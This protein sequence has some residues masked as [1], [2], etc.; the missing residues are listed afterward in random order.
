MLTLAKDDPMAKKVSRPLRLRLV[1]PRLVSLRGLIYINLPL[2]LGVISLILFLF[3]TG[4][5]QFDG[6]DSSSQ[7]QTPPKLDPPPIPSLDP[8][9]D[10][11]IQGFFASSCLESPTP[12]A[13]ACIFKKNPIADKGS[14]LSPS[15]FPLLNVGDVLNSYLNTD[16]F[17]S[18]SPK[19]PLSQLRLIP[20]ESPR[21]PYPIENNGTDDEASALYSPRIPLIGRGDASKYQTYAVKLPDQLSTTTFNIKTL[22]DTNPPINLPEQKLSINKDGNWK[23]SF[24][25]DPNMHLPH[26]HTSYWLH[27]TAL[28]IKELTGS[29][30]PEGQELQVIP[31]DAIDFIRL[32]PTLSYIF[33]PNMNAYWDPYNKTLSFGV[34]SW[35]TTSRNGGT[36]HIPLGLDTSIVAHELGHAILDLAS[37][38]GLD[39]NPLLED[40]CHAESFNLCSH[41]VAGSPIAIHEGVGDILSIFLFPDSTAIGELLSNSIYGDTHCGQLRT[42]ERI[43][44]IGLQAKDLFNACKDEG[45]PGEIHAMGSI[46]STIWHGIFQ[47]AMERGGESLREETY[48]LFFEHLKNISSEDNFTS[49]RDTIKTLDQSLF[50]GQF[51]DDVDAEYNSIGYPGENKP[52]E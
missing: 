29:F 38:Q 13:N 36:L 15:E 51:S 14:S 31:L 45:L 43:R 44:N 42:A 22:S 6:L 48:K 18:T 16:Q 25:D 50:E 9:D 17:I 41:D 20:E 33:G 1:S 7:N 5:S 47:R 32:T 40:F 8:S 28:R 3:S 24:Q 12:G 21:T 4:C 35:S 39:M 37:E 30:Y 34:S 26:I 19:A 27:Y 23:Y 52:D 11:F 46:Y 10:D 2:L 49:L